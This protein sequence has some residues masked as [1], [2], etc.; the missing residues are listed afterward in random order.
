MT[1]TQDNT[2]PGDRP[3]KNSPTSDY[4]VGYC[5]PPAAHRFKHG[6]K[7]NPRGRKKG[8]R[9]RKVVIHDVLF[10]AVT[11]REGGEIRQM[12]ALEAVLKKMLSKALAGDS[13]A[14]L[15]IIGIA[16]KE[17]IL[18][19][20]QEQVVENLSESD[21]AIMEDVKR[22]MAASALEDP[23]QCSGQADSA[24]KVAVLSRNEPVAP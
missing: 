6:N 20:E 24:L 10:E 7:A 14:A 18:T 8:S 16:Q 3:A 5:K 9:N 17:G 12:S 21:L 1:N 13:K 4:D 19:P 15:T 2:M 23:L 11:V 22:R